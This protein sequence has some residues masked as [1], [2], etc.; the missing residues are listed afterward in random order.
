MATKAK[1][2]TAENPNRVAVIAT[3]TGEPLI[4]RSNPSEEAV[5][6]FVAEVKRRYHAGEVGGPSGIPARL[7]LSASFFEDEGDLHDFNKTGTE[8]DLS[9]ITDAP[10]EA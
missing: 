9:G 7:P 10:V 8:I 1:T 3:H 6:S 2:A 5:R 4:L